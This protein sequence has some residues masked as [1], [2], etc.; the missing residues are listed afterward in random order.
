MKSKI[1]LEV[2]KTEEKIVSKTCDICQN[3]FENKKED[4]MSPFNNF[5]SF[6]I[7]GGYSNNFIPDGYNMS[8][9]ICEKCFCTK[10]LPLFKTTNQSSSFPYSDKDLKGK[11]KFDKVKKEIIEKANLN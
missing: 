9:D 8:F 10:L 6:D 5:P 7:S 11:F 1:K 2:L 3:V 4:Y